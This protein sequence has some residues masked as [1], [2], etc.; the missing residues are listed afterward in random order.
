MPTPFD[1]TKFR[2]GAV[3]WTESGSRVKYRG[4][5]AQVIRFTYLDQ[6]ADGY[7]M[8]PNAVDWA[9]KHW[10]MVDVQPQVHVGGMV[11][12]PEPPK[13]TPPSPLPWTAERAL[14]DFRYED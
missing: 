12:T 6:W 5:D 8:Q 11:I 13:P 2:L 1:M 3:A 4:E 9:T 7:L 10:T 14:N